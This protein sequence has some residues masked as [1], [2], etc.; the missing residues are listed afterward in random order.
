MLLGHHMI[1][2]AAIIPF[3]ITGII[4]F[5]P[6]A[7]PVVLVLLAI[8]AAATAWRSVRN[9]SLPTDKRPLTVIGLLFVYIFASTVWSD[10]PRAFSSAVSALAMA[11]FG[12][13]L[14][15]SLTR[16]PAELFDRA[17]RALTIA[18]VA[19]LVLYM[20]NLL[21]GF[22]IQRTLNNLPDWYDFAVSNV[23]KRSEALFAIT[24]W[25]LALWLAMQ[26]R[27]RHAWLLLGGAVVLSPLF[28]GVN[29]MLALVAGIGTVAVGT[30]QPR[31]LRIGGFIALPLI[32]IIA[33]A[34]GLN[35][36]HARV[37]VEG[38]VGASGNY[39]LHIWDFT[40]RAAL[41][42]LPFGIGIDGSRSFN[43]TDAKTPDGQNILPVH[44][45]NVFLQVWLEFGIVGA[46]LGSIIGFF[47]W[48]RL[49]HAPA[50]L[51]PYLFGQVVCAIVLLSTAYGLWQAWWLAG[52]I[53]TA[54]LTATL[55][56]R[57][58]A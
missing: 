47:V 28:T 10:S 20:A 2:I 57:E 12:A 8:G 15:T 51:Q 49:V 14:F 26:R 18:F 48:W 29:S 53:F 16:W 4:A 46:L 52:H 30:L 19:A 17:M 45:H 34:V 40:A 55:L 27:A 7:L 22:P 11:G 35:A 58:V 31:L 32:F 43:T 42:N 21:L 23:G 41:D 50:A 38:D 44:P 13:L 3:I 56:K 25:P 36:L 5:L 33:L 6:R 39:R 1:N 9:S 54:A 37:P 24:V